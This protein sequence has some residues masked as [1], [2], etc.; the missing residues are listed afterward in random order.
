MANNSYSGSS[1]IGQA[2]TAA[3]GGSAADR[4]FA[5]S[6]QQAMS[7]QARARAAGQGS[8]AGAGRG[9]GGNTG[10]PAAYVSGA[11][12]GRGTGGNAG[13]PAEW[14]GGAGGGRGNGGN[15]GNPAE[16]AGGAGGG[17]GGQGG[18]AFGEREVPGVTPGAEPPMIFP[19]SVSYSDVNGVTPAETLRVR[20]RVPPKYLNIATSGP[21]KELSVENFG[22]IIFPY[23]PSISYEVKADYSASNPLHS[24][25]AINF[26]QRSSV[27][28]IT[29][30][31][32]FSVE[33]YV[34]AGVYL[35]TVR[36]LKALT[37]MRSGGAS[38]DLDSGAPPPIC[39]LDAYGEMM[40]KNV[41]VVITSFRIELPDG[42]DY[43]AFDNYLY[44]SNSVP[45]LSTIAITC[46]PMY[47]RSEMQQFSVTGYLN[48]AYYGKGYI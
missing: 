21:Q 4:M 33:N 18:P 25:F 35:S 47:S 37:K 41:P 14:V 3:K 27:S 32:K 44:G 16:W 12:A 17:R 46:L 43:F 28:A 6:Q 45:T 19:P 30:S 20:L 10:N 38:G 15:P 34:D 22:G 42:V 24:N 13:N 5:K 48:N 11:G 39:R 36:L 29:I 8:G 31:G 26:Y 23:T 7:A 9:V 2:V 40:L 1:N